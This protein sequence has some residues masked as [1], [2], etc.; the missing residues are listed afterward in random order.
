MCSRLSLVK[1]IHSWLSV[2]VYIED[3][4]GVRLEDVVVV[5]EEGP[6]ILSGR[7]AKDWLDI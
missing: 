2:G 5:T 3:Y 1:P 7:Q 6:E 4:A